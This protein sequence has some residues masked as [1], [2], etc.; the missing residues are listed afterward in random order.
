[1]A[2]RPGAPRVAL[3][4]RR[5]RGRAPD[6]AERNGGRAERANRRVE[7]HAIEVESGASGGGT[8]GAPAPVP[9]IEEKTP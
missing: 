4:R 8:T 1:M 3:H 7:L 9:Q 5:L 2:R 6:R